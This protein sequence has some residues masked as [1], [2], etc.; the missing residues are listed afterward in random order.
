MKLLK[1]LLGRN[2]R[3]L[4]PDGERV[5]EPL[6]REAFAASGEKRFELSSRLYPRLF[7]PDWDYV[8]LGFAYVKVIDN[9]VDVEPDA[10]KALAYLSRQRRLLEACYGGA[11]PAAGELPAPDRFGHQFFLQDAR[12]GGPLR[13]CFEEVFAVMEFDVRRRGRVLSHE[14]LDAHLVATGEPGIRFLT[15]FMAPEVELP[16]AYL[17]LASR[18]YLWADSLL[19]LEEDLA[20]G[21]INVPAEAIE[22]FQLTPAA[23]DRGLPLWVAEQAGRAMGYFDQALAQT[24]E[25]EHPAL[26]LFCKLYL[27][28]KRK[29]LVRLL[30]SRGISAAA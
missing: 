19:D 12:A 21:L 6:L 22:R 15:T 16:P 25:L 30:E 20:D 2:R 26:I 14:E 13:S 23:D 7:G 24:D 28:R 11:A 1:V 29:K 9:V 17:A 4:Y 10:E 18:A 27:G 8:L 5:P 3:V